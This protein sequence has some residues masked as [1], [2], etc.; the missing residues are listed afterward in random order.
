MLR[1][2]AVKEPQYMYI[3][4]PFFDVPIHYIEE[5]NNVASLYGNLA[6]TRRNYLT[7][8]DS[9]INRSGPDSY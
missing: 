7:V 2:T 1:H 8:D 9:G 4:G 3:E 5:R 6:I